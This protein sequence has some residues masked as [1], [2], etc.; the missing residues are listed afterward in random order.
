MT[1][2]PRTIKVIPTE[3]P[4]T[5]NYASVSFRPNYTNEVVEVEILFAYRKT[6]GPDKR[7]RIVAAR[8]THFVA[9]LYY[10]PTA[11]K[12]K[13]VPVVAGSDSDLHLTPE[14]MSLSLRDWW[15]DEFRSGN[16]VFNEG[17]T[18]SLNRY[19]FDILTTDELDA[20]ASS[21]F[22]YEWSARRDSFK[23]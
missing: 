5:R 23:Y 21:T 1:I 4:F 15:E 11:P 19:S 12:N 18:Y 7:V 16:S 20:I 14:V 3:L 10:I 2:T 13:I 8:N 22:H 9:D 6:N 17:Q